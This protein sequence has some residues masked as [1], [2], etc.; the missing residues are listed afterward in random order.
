[1]DAIE[2]LTFILRDYV[3]LFEMVEKMIQVLLIGEFNA[4]VIHYQGKLDGTLLVGEEAGC[5]LR[6]I[7]STTSKMVDMVIV[8]QLSCLRETVSL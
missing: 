8:C 6:R 5:E 1:M 7:V 4:E 3:T 2:P